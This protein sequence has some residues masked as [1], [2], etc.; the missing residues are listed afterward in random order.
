MKHN[1]LKVL[2]VGTR[3]V[4]IRNF[5]SL[6]S[7]EIRELMVMSDNQDP[8]LS[9]VQTAIVE[10]SIRNPLRIRNSVSHIEK[11]IREFSPDVIHVHQAG[12]HAYLAIRANRQTGAPVVVTAWGS[13][14]LKVPDMG[15]MYRKM[16]KYILTRADYLTADSEFLA[17][18]MRAI[19]G[20]S[21]REILV[22]NYGVDPDEAD[23]AKEKIIYSNRLHKPLYRI[24]R[25]IRYF[26]DFRRA[27]GDKSWKLIIAGEGSET[28]K[29]RKIARDENVELDTGF[30]GWLDKDYNHAYYM[31]SRI[32]V[33]IP[34]TDA[35]SVSL[36]EAMSCGCI[37]V[38]SDLP[39]NREWILD[40]ING[41]IE[42]PRGE[43]P[44]HRALE[45][46]GEE[47]M[48]IN[49]SLIR[50]KATREISR[51]QFT[52]LY[53]KATDRL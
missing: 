22:A 7:G 19:A 34:S 43:N 48:R 14:I 9:D 33:S 51:E 24:D 4:H 37:P 52:T 41:I 16:V 18:R 11:V 8:G 12:T 26:A 27:T 20:D 13:D 30:T 42:Q 28:G 5:V 38:V 32:F 44:F 47:A 15:R 40:G 29:L 2:L 31:R 50:K 39:S 23:I 36:L 53:K 25:I 3:S 45:I 6:I 21:E 1:K 46:P 17:R 35:T 49:R 10:F